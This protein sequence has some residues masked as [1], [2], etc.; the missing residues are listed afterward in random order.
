MKKRSW[1]SLGMLVG[2]IFLFLSMTT[3]P[4]QAQVVVSND[5]Q[6]SDL[7]FTIEY[8]SEWYARKETDPTT[9]AYFFSREQIK[10]QSDQY[11]AGISVMISKG[12]ASSTGDWNEFKQT[13][14]NDSRS[15]GMTVEDIALD[16]IDGHPAFAFIT[17]SNRNNIC[18]VYIKKDQ[19]LAALVLEAPHE[20][21]D[22]FKPMYMKTIEKFK[23]TK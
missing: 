14:T 19:D 13:L 12:L 15:K 9:E 10:E 1:L 8:P 5:V 18:F 4:V 3:D 22:T 23:F 20:E 6:A 21:W 16:N 2:F 17:K 7:P 11:R